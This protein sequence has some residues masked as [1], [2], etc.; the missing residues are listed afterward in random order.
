MI[1]V[2]ADTTKEEMAWRWWV[3]IGSSGHVV[4]WL[5]ELLPL[6]AERRVCLLLR[7]VCLFVVWRTGCWKL[8]FY[9]WSR[10]LFGVDERITS[11]FSTEQ[12]WCSCALEDDARQVYHLFIVGLRHQGDGWGITSRTKANNSFSTISWCHQ[13]TAW[14]P[15]LLRNYFLARVWR[16]VSFHNEAFLF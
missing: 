4:G 6:R 14:N 2:S 16:H 12:I 10:Q 3:G 8:L 15:F 11:A 13:S 5:E 1:W 7:W 9:L